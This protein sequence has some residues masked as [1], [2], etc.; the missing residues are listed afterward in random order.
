MTALF[1]IIRLM[2]SSHSV[3]KFVRESKEAGFENESVS[4]LKYEGYRLL[5][6]N[7]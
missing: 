5:K 7:K 3:F 2:I 6:M 4:V 1:I